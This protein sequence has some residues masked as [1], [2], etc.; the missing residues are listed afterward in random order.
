M[1]VII[2]PLRFEPLRRR[3]VPDERGPS[4]TWKAS[5]GRRGVAVLDAGG[6]R[7]AC[8]AVATLAATGPGAR[9]LRASAASDWRPGR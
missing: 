1:P 7:Q 3:I 9:Q 4:Y 6:L 2:A 8:A 5:A